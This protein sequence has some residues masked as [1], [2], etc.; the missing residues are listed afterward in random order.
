MCLFFLFLLQLSLLNLTHRPLT[1]VS[2]FFMIITCRRERSS[3]YSVECFNFL[4]FDLK[5]ATVHNRFQ[6]Q[7]LTKCTICVI[8]QRFAGIQRKSIILC[9][10]FC[11]ILRRLNAPL[12]SPP[13]K[14]DTMLAIPG[15]G[16]LLS[17]KNCEGV[18]RTQ[19]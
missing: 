19:L 13:W 8:S 2:I 3:S 16:S 1:R 11:A 15:R 4:V 17:R 5:I 6:N 14:K 9:W 7:M 12:I 18:L 10:V